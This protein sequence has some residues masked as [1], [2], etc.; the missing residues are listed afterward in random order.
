MDVGRMGVQCRDASM[1]GCEHAG[2]A[3]MAGMQVWPVCER[4]GGVQPCRG[5]AI[6]RRRYRVANRC[7][8]YLAPSQRQELNQP[9]EPSL[10]VR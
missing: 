3:S 1:A 2:G 8:E 10:R 5:R 9:I 6:M 7:G 4:A